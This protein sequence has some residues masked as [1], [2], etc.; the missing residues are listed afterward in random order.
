MATSS[1]KF[2]PEAKSPVHGYYYWMVEIGIVKV[3]LD[4]GVFEALPEHGDMAV[5]DLAEKTGA[6]LSLLQRFSNFLVAA[7]VLASESPGRVAHTEASLRLREGRIK[8]L[9]R[10]IF[11]FFLVPASQWEAYFETHGLREPTAANS[12]PYGLATGH[13]Q[14][15][16][17]EV[18]ETRPQRSAE[19]NRAMEATVEGMPITGM[20][21][22][23]WIGEYATRP[24][25]SGAASSRPVFV[26]VGG[27]KGQALKA[28]LQEN[29]TIPAARCVLQ[30]QPEVVDQAV[31][32]SD[33][34]LQPVTKIG[35]SF[36]DEQPVKGALVYH[37]RRVL[38]DWP[39]E[40]CIKILSRVSAACADDSRVLVSEQ[41]LPD[42]PSLDLAA[43]DIWMMNFGGKRRNARL[44]QDIVAKA[45]LRIVSVSRD[46]VSGSGVIEMVLCGNE[47]ST[48]R[49]FQ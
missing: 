47:L 16:L 49:G 1:Q 10:H 5:A 7:Q 41:L 31:Q 32:E 15:T 34:I 22:F 46:D 43:F 2:S 26:D 30:D 36:F 48:Q 14:K 40:D 18:L 25:E 39:D 4:H 38:N 9:F 11:D 8:L 29:P 13:P 21:D 24:S 27:G 45:G 28:I 35:V 17:Y 19:F 23:G 33:S 44:F 6:E 3:F 20:Y 42:S 37:I 12:T